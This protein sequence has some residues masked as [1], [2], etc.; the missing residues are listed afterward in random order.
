M[1]KL[2][3]YKLK[4][5]IP[6]TNIR[7]VWIK[8]KLIHVEQLPETDKGEDSG[9]ESHAKQAQEPK[10]GRKVQNVPWPEKGVNKI[11][12]KLKYIVWTSSVKRKPKVKLWIKR[13]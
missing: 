2:K 5:C 10:C 3:G 6:V 9:V 7:R 11:Q 12:E 4:I 13:A 1:F 8:S